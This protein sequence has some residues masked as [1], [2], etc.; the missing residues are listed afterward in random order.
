MAKST[1]QVYHRAWVLFQECL[2][3]LNQCNFKISHL[4]VSSKTVLLF[5]S[6]LNIKGLA[7]SSITTYVAAIGYVHKVKSL[8]D[9]TSNYLVQK[10][11]SSITKIMP[12]RDSRLPITQFIL[13]R[14]IQSVDSVI[15]NQY[16]RVLI[17]TMFAVAFYGLFRVG[18]LTIQNSGNISLMYDHLKLY[19]DRAVISITNY[20]NNK[21]NQPFEIV[22]HPQ[23][24]LAC[25]FRL[26]IEFI[27]SR[28]N[29]SGPLFCFADGKPVSRN[30]FNT[31]LKNCLLFIGLDPSHYKSHSFRIGGASFLYSLGLSD[32]Q[33]KLMGRWNSDAFLLYIRNQKFNIIKK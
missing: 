31:Q 19:R 14:L 21:N 22:L 29:T 7:A 9:P 24:H 11:L 12:A 28:G 16:N 26:L 8:P 3:I 6:Y 13:F 33:I 25:P 20:K 1:F 27:N 2:Q 4:P 10:S 32:V 18:E 15:G 17:K 5:I 30:Y 23:N